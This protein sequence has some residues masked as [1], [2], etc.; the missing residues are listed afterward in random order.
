[1][2]LA[3]A[4]QIGRTGL[5]ASQT[6]LQVVGQNL[7]NLSTEGYHRQKITLAPERYQEIGS[8]AMLSRAVA[9]SVGNTAVFSLPGSTKAVQLAMEKLILPELGHI[10]QLLE[11]T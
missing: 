2:G 1:M 3:G 9:G 5:L 7:A 11:G 6:A 4:L 8:G 10:V